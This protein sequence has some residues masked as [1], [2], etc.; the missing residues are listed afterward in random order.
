MD[1]MR[2]I[3]LA[4]SPFIAFLLLAPL[5]DAI[6]AIRTGE[7]KVPWRFGQL[8]VFKRTEDPVRFDRSIKFLFWFPLVF[9]LVLVITV[10]LL[11]D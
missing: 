11:L 1:E 5:F 3:L 4:V 6:M 2:D 7:L 9:L 8:H 10:L